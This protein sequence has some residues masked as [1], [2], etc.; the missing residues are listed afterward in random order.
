MPIHFWLLYW[1]A[2][3]TKWTSRFSLI[4]LHSDS[5]SQ[6]THPHTQQPGTVPHEAP[7]PWDPRTLWLLSS[8][9]GK[10]WC[11]IPARIFCEVATS[12]IPLLFPK[13][14]GPSSE[15]E[16]ISE[17][18]KI[19]LDASESFP[20]SLGSTE[21]QPLLPCE[22]VVA[23]STQ[24]SWICPAGRQAILFLLDRHLFFF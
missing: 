2:W 17:Q 19:T 6:P 7:T 8:R 14:P 10:L 1:A 20:T 24:S 13:H 22:K 18:A 12:E 9:T 4:F 23:Q 11:G 3:P 5:K 21:P 15:E 16:C